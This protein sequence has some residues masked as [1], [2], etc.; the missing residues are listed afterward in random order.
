MLTDDLLI[1]C[2]KVVKQN[3]LYAV[4]SARRVLRLHRLRHCLA[5][6]KTA[7]TS[8]LAFTF[9]MWRE[10]VWLYKDQT[11]P[12]SVIQQICSL[13]RS[14]CI[15]MMEIINWHIGYIYYYYMCVSVQALVVFK[16]RW[17]IYNILH[18][19]EILLFTVN[20]YKEKRFK[21]LFFMFELPCNKII[22]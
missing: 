2:I 11:L 10:L 5:N 22:M 14:T 3:K 20:Y 17:L 4:I 13:T 9:T 19:K 15:L 21:N 16:C 6:T 18:F 12:A 8:L 1:H 7:Y